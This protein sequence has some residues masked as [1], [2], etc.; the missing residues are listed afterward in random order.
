MHRHIIRS[1][2]AFRDLDHLA[3]Y[4]QKDSPETAVRFLHAAEACF[5]LIA[6]I[7]E[8]GT[9]LNF[10][11]FRDSGIHVRTIKGFENHLVFYRP[12]ETSVEIIRVLHG[13]RDL[14]SAWDEKD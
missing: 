7:P 1:E 3:S 14:S 8:G 11:R 12:S 9:L 4:I 13:A 5:D 6:Q 2:K 10:G